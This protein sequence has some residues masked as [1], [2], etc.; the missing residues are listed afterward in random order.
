LTSVV[1]HL[2]RSA[3]LHEGAEQTDSQL[4]EAFRRSRDPLALV[5][6]VRRLA[7]LVWGFCRRTLAQH[8]EAEDAFQA[9]FLVLL[10]KAASI[11]TP[12]R[13]PNWLYGV[14][15]RTACKARQRAAKRY[16]RE[17][18]VPVLPEPPSEPPDDT[19]GLDLRTVI[20]E[21]LGRLPEKYRVV[22]LLCDLEERTRQEAA[23][24]LRVPP[25]TVASRLATGRALLARRL[26]R[27]GLGVS[28]TGL[29]AA[30]LHQA[31]SG[32]V[33]AALLANTAKAVG[34]LAAGDAAAAG[35]VSAEVSPLA[36][37]VLRAMAV[38][39][40]KTAGVVLVLATLGLAGGVV[41]CHA[42]AARWAQTPPAPGEVGRFPTFE[43]PGEVWRFPVE[44]SAQSVA[45]S[46]DGR[47]IVIGTLGVG[48]PVRV[49]EVSTG[50][51]V[52]RTIGYDWCWT[53]AYSPDG[54]SIAV[55]FAEKP[56]LILDAR[57][58]EVCRELP[59]RGARSVCFSPD[60]R[61]LAAWHGDY[62]L[63]LWDVAQGRVLH[64]FPGGKVGAV[65]DAAFTPDG[66]QLLIIGPD[67]VALYLYEVASGKEVRRF[68][69]HTLRVTD[70]AVSADGRRAL[71]CGLDGTI[72]LWDIQTGKELR[73][74]ETDDGGLRRVAFCPDGRRAVSSGYGKTL[75]LWD[76][77]TG[78]ELYRLAG[79]DG[80]VCC[81]AVS[82]DGR[83]AL[84][85]CSDHTARLWRLPDPAPGP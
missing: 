68:E 60:S 53:V 79:H 21:E 66:Q 8:H 82:P 49:C 35:L 45:F 72:R 28:A 78:Q 36:D 80:V 63:R 52:L 73:R 26:L 25:G 19:S 18:Q 75:R 22:I 40:Q 39:R 29:A 50:A 57:T 43:A 16:T 51:E 85:G 46:P 48:L 58:G 55:G 77:L 2:R 33:P 69:G 30:G 32:A 13:L 54:K 9:T 61:L 31:A 4:L 67:N 11:R 17:K 41:T 12:E 14:A 7:P 1:Q 5:A 74:L 24:Q 20:D 38:A 59:S 70:V 84:S 71:S 23:R 44:D 83:Y 10:R 56:I 42:L 62:R 65:H 6:L 3:L 47:R 76:L 37:R 15:Y 34:L 64:D 27:R 81:V